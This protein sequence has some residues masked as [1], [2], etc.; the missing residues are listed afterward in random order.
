[1]A[2]TPPRILY[3]DQ[4][5]SATLSASPVLAA[6][7]PVTNLQNTLRTAVARSTSTADQSILGD[8]GAT[9]DVDGCVAWRHNLTPSSTWRLRLY[10]GANQTG[11]TLYDS[12]AIAATPTG[13]AGLWGHDGMGERCRWSKI[14]IPSTVAARSFRIDF[15]DSGNPDGYIECSRLLMGAAW[16]LSD[17]QGGVEAGASLEWRDN[18][19]HARTDAGSQIILTGSQWRAI[20]FQLNRLTDADRETLTRIRQIC[21][22]SRPVFVSLFPGD[23]DVARERDHELVGT[24]ADASPIAWIGTYSAS[25]IE[26]E[27]C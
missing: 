7:L 16:T 17:Q 9:V 20:K 15:S 6:T 5:P 2:I 11:T 18:D 24:F 1:M 23:E 19:R 8:F 25:T 21:G 10:S 4:I 13:A 26:I 14:W 12:T 3:A 22:R 27:E